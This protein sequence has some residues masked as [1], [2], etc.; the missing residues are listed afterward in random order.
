MRG[1]DANAGAKTVVRAHA[2]EVFN[3]TVD[4]EGAFLDLDTPADYER[5]LALAARLSIE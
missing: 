5:A 4:D 2:H 1:A 3:L